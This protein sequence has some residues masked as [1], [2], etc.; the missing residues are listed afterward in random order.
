[1]DAFGGASRPRE[2]HEISQWLER[3]RGKRFDDYAALWRW[4]VQDLE[5]FWQAIWDYFGIE[6]QRRRPCAG[7]PQHARANGFLGTP[8]L[9]KT[10][11]ARGAARSG[12]VSVHE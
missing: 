11:A 5:G 12:S 6:A 2:C 9:C 8:E 1:V 10:C 3:E 4:S 7:P